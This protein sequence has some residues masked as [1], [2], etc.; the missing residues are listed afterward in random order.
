MLRIG[1]TQRVEVVPDR[2]E[3]RDCL[4]QAWTPLLAENGCWPIPIPNRVETVS[5]MLTDLALDGIVLTGGNDLAHLPGGQTAAPERDALEARLLEAC[6]GAGVP[7]LGVC[8]GLQMLVHYHGGEL[9]PVANHVATRHR[10][11]VCPGADIPLT[12]REAVNSFH[13]F[14]C[15]ED[16]LGPELRVIATAADGTVEAVAHRTLP[17]WGVMWH[18]ERDPRDRGDAALLRA[19]FSG[20]RV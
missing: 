14:G 17:Q 1:V 7:V 4:D 6:S 8:R 2:D 13:A 19:L 12:D 18:P 3:R 16:N 20:S 10:L 15:Y 5:A 9:V 11:V